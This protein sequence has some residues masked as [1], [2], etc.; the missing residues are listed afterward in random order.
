M[1]HRLQWFSTYR[2]GHVH[3]PTFLHRWEWWLSWNRTVI[4]VSTTLSFTTDDKDIRTHSMARD[5]LLFLPPL[6][7]L[8]LFNWSLFPLRLMAVPDSKGELLGTIVAGFH[9]PVSK[10]TVLK[11]WVFLW[12]KCETVESFLSLQCRISI[13]CINRVVIVIS[14][15]QKPKGLFPSSVIWQWCLCKCTFAVLSSSCTKLS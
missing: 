13:L 10:P 15:I 7:S 9:R 8:F 11:Q 14:W 1:C 4:A 5:L 6:L 2:N 3:P 12:S